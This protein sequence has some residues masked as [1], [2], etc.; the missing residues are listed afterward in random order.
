MPQKTLV[1]LDSDA[2][3]IAL[4]RGS[5][6]NLGAITLGWPLRERAGVPNRRASFAAN[7]EEA[8][9]VQLTALLAQVGLPPSKVQVLDALPADWRYPT[10]DG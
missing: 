1:L 3:R 4:D 5:P 10:G 7:F 2:D 6:K 8:F 9:D